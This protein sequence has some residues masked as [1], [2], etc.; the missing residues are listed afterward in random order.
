MS[1]LSVLLLFVTYSLLSLCEKILNK[2]F[3]L[4]KT[5]KRDL[6]ECH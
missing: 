5:P 2:L 3:L 6:T 1:V 4:K